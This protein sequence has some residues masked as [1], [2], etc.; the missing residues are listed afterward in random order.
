VIH[1]PSKRKLLIFPLSKLGTWLDGAGE[2]PYQSG[3]VFLEF[4]EKNLGV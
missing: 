4:I 1:I 3:E 2:K